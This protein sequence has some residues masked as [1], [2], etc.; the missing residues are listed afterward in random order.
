MGAEIDQQGRGAGLT[1]QQEGDGVGAWRATVKR[2][3]HRFLQRG[4]PMLIEQLQQ[5]LRLTAGRFS[6]RESGVD[7]Q[8]GLRH[9]LLQTTAA[10]RRDRAVLGFQ[11]GFLMCG[12]DDELMP[13]VG[14]QM[15]GDLGKAIQDSHGGI[16]G[17]QRER[18]ADG[19]RGN[20]V[21]VEVEPHINGF[22]RGNGFDAV[23]RENMERRG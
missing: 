11:Q 7:Q 17:S 22:V 21:V 9:Q 18:S 13:V 1:A 2:L 4:H 15:T 14:S 20:R 10:G 8:F 3:P 16:G 6:L 12:I 19:F 5:L 23:G